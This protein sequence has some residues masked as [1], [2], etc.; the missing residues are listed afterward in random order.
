MQSSSAV[1]DAET[2]FEDE[3]IEQFARAQIS[4]ALSKILNLLSKQTDFSGKDVHDESY[5]KAVIENLLEFSIAASARIESL[6]S[7]NQDLVST[8]H[9]IVGDTSNEGQPAGPSIMPVGSLYAAIR[10]PGEPSGMMAG[11]TPRLIWTEFSLSSPELP[12][13]LQS[14]FATLDAGSVQGLESAQLP[15]CRGGVLW[16]LWFPAVQATA[17]AD[18]FVITLDGPAGQ[19]LHNLD[20]TNEP[21]YRLNEM[22]RFRFSIHPEVYIR[23]FFH[24]VRGQIGRFTILEDESDLDG[25]IPWRKDIDNWEAAVVRA[26]YEIRKL[27]MPLSRRGFKASGEAVFRGCVL[28]K[29]AVFHTNVVLSPVGTLELTDENLK[30]ENL[31]V[32]VSDDFGRG[33]QEEVTPVP[34][35]SGV[36]EGGHR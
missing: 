5:L 11:R 15:F 4:V 13:S 14:V 32:R 8:I 19:E 24:L 21:L 18:A 16:H 2:A 25:P 31:P 9:D 33:E 10:S 22:K 30:L 27:L 6:V 36:N 3:T 29:N 17:D 23:C 35:E 7:D 20:W 34:T 26:K 1:G 12:D 28:F